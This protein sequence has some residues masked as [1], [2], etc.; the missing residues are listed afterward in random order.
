MNRY[1]ELYRAEQLPVFQNRMFRTQEDA[2]NCVKGD[3]VLVRD[4]ETGLIFNQAFRPELMEYDSNYQNEQAVSSVFQTHLEEV[5]GIIGKHFSDRTLI[6]VGCGKGYFLEHLSA[7]GF[8]VTGLD[9]TYEGENPNVIKAYFTPE[10]GLSADG[11]ILRHVLEHIQDPVDFLEHV[12]ASNGGKG[13]IYIEVPCFD[14]ICAHRAWFDIFY[15]H[16]NYFR[17]NDFS[18]IFGKVCESGHIFGGQYLYIVADLAS[19]CRP[20]LPASDGFAFP[21]DF[22]NT[23]TCYADMIRAQRDEIDVRKHPSVIWGGASKGVIFA[24]FMQRAGAT[25]DYVVDINPAKQGKFL[26]A[27]GLRVSSPEEVLTRIEPGAT[28][29]VMNGNY[30]PEIRQA[31]LNKFKYLTVDHENL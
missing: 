5:S 19:L 3:V 30:L 27:T 18:R 4:M 2:Q 28:V 15:E 17:I 7:L 12:A 24:L 14:W 26:A 25:I 20:R 8:K 23:V 22:L 29:F 16:V 31:T 11:I 21:A 13:K 1:E 6:E 10:I 9:P